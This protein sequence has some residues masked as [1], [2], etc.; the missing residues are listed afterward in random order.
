MIGLDRGEPGCRGHIRFNGGCERPAH[1]TYSRS[2][3]KNTSGCPSKNESSSRKEGGCSVEVR[4]PS[5]GGGREK[6]HSRR[7][8]SAVEQTPKSTILDRMSRE[9]LKSALRAGKETHVFPRQEARTS[10]VKQIPRS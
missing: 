9:R 1:G 7:K 8:T 3:M 5:I 2:L 4:K 10:C 6:G